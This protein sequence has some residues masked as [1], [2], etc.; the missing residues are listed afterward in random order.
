MDSKHGTPKAG[1]EK[2]RRAAGQEQAHTGER[3]Q[4]DREPSSPGIAE[5]GE[6]LALACQALGIDV[7]DV[8][9]YRIY[10][11]RVVLIE[12]PAGR[13]RIWPRKENG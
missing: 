6:P 3:R 1:E 13:K 7:A 9:S 10:D 2:R 5:Q 4:P 12:G 8:L 11:E